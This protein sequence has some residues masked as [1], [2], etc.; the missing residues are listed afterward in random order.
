MY[1]TLKKKKVLKGDSLSVWRSCITA[2]WVNASNPRQ[3]LQSAQLIQAGLNQLSRSLS[4]FNKRTSEVVLEIKIYD[5]KGQ[6]KSNISLLKC[7][8]MPL[9]PYFYVN[10][11]EALCL[12]NKSKL[13]PH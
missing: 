4:N 1:G 8:M 12:L 6:K 10:L 7:N 11:G 9:H 2:E 5:K 13:E 3:W